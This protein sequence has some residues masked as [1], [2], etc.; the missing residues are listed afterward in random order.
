MGQR[1]IWVVLWRRFGLIGLHQGFCGG[2]CSWRLQ[3]VLGDD[4]LFVSLAWGPTS[5]LP[6][7]PKILLLEPK[8]YMYEQISGI[9]Y[10]RRLQLQKI[11]LEATNFPPAQPTPRQRTATRKASGSCLRSHACGGPLP[12][13]NSYLCTHG[14][15]WQGPAGTTVCKSRRKNLQIPACF[16]AW[17][18]KIRDAPEKSSTL[19]FLEDWSRMPEERD[20]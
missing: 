2:R 20:P 8:N 1:W 17:K 5:S 14:N 7:R 11:I 12:S 13:P 18:P 4:V 19:T 6:L 3:S 10:F 15:V 9:D 16:W